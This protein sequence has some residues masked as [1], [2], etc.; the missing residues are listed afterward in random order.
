MVL[1]AKTRMR[2]WQLQLPPRS[3]PTEVVPPEIDTI[4][5]TEGKKTYYKLKPTHAEMAPT[6]PSKK[7]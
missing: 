2:V 3:T 4:T 1:T 5:V 6:A 7:P